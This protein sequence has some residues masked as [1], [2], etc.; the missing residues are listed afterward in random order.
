MKYLNFIYDEEP[1]KNGKRWS[2]KAR[3][4]DSRA[5]VQDIKFAPHYL[6]LKLATISADGV[7]RIYEATDI[8]NLAHWT[9]M[10][11]ERICLGTSLTFIFRRTLK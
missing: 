11:F 10:V 7:L 5:T 2:E 8:I 4:Q 3:L 6:G 9:L 1:K